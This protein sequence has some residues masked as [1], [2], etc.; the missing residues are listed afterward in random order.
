MKQNDS[1]PIEGRD[2]RGRWD[3]LP[4]AVA[5]LLAVGVVAGLVYNHLGMRTKSGQKVGSAAVSGVD[6]SCRLPVVAGS[7]GAF[8]SFPDGAVTIDHDIA[9]NPYKGGY[10]YTYDAQVRRWVPVPGSAVSPD[11]HSYAYLAQTSGVPG[12]MTSMTLHTHEIVSGKD[13]VLWESAGSPMGPSLLTW[14]PGGI[15]FSAVF[16]PAGSAEGP[17]YPALYVADP[18]HPSA[19]RRVGPNPA[20]QLPGPGQP[21]YSGPDIFMYVGSDAAWATGNRMPTQAPSPNQ[22][23]PPGSFG[24]DRILRMDLRS[25]SV[26]TWYT[27]SGTDLVTLMGLDDE[28]RPILSLFPSK[29]SIGSGSPANTFELPPARLLLLIG[30]NRVVQLASGNTDFHPG[31]LPLSDSHGIWFGSWDSVWLYTASGGFRQVA[32]IPAGLFPSPSPPPGMPPKS[33]T[34]SG[35]KPGMP[36]YM[37]GTLVAAAGPCT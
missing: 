4:G 3:W 14:L 34:E 21:D 1:T 29:P 11:G 17:A 20:P 12:E 35:G 18:Y 8:I 27:V 33:V 24:P 25:G 2:R 15:Y 16:L 19:P 7:S 5:A 9:L 22:P 31:S 37:Q 26:S 23:P 6:F 36:A 32:T 13:R 30:P 10:G 28:G